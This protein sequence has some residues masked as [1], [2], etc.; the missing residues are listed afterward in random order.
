MRHLVDVVFPRLLITRFSPHAARLSVLLQDLGIFSIA[1]PLLKVE[2]TDEFHHADLVFNRSYD[3]IIAV[4]VH[5]VSYTAEAIFERWPISNYFAVGKATQRE[6]ECAVKQSVYRPKKQFNSEGLLDLAQLQNVAQKRIL[7]LRG[8]GGSAFLADI[9]RQRGAI[10]D[11]YQP[12]QRVAVDNVGANLIKKCQQKQVNGIIL[13]SIEL[14]NQLVYITENVDMDW[15]KSITIYT[16]S[17]RITEYA[18]VLG[19]H[20]IITLPGISDEEIIGYFKAIVNP[21]RPILMKGHTDG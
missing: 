11:Y 12:Y 20:K 13:T 18:C 15:L 5:A 8:K 17:K 9:L 3:R 6:F 4:S 16:I 1:Q 14:L 2:K 10:V 21:Q 19:W 7:I